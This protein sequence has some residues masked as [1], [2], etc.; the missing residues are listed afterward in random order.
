MFYQILDKF[1]L[2]SNLQTNL[3]VNNN[4][5][6]DL[7]EKIWYVV[8]SNN[9]NISVMNT[10]NSYLSNYQYILRKNDI[11]KLGRIKFL[12]RD[13][14]VVDGNFITT[15]QTFRPYAEFE[16]KIFF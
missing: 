1:Y 2:C 7:Q 8:K 5:L 13:M 11:I 15:D 6:T 9:S 10:N 16:Y 12:V 14:N 4:T 3:P